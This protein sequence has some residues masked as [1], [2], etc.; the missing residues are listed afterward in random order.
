MS[1]PTLAA[2]VTLETASVDTGI[3]R[4]RKGLNQ[5]K[6]DTE[7]NMSASQR[8]FGFFGR[9]VDGVRDSI[10][11][12]NGAIAGAIG[13]A[14][15]MAIG[16]SVLNTADQV[17]KM[18]DRLGLT[19][20][21]L[22]KYQ[23]A[24]KLAGVE[25]EQFE[26]AFGF[27][28]R[29]MAEGKL[30]YTDIN[31]ALL[32]LAD[33]TQKA[34]DGIERARI[35]T[36]AFGARGG[37]RMIPFL[38]QGKEGIAALGAEAE[39]LGIVLGDDTIRKAEQFKDQLEILGDVIQKNFSQA[40]LEGFIGSSKD[41]RDIYTDPNF[42]QSI[43]DLGSAFGAIADGMLAAVS[44][45]KEFYSIGKKI[46]V[47]M[48]YDAA[49]KATRAVMGE[50][51]NPN[52]SFTKPQTV[53][54]ATFGSVEA[55]SEKE[56]AK[57]LS[58]RAYEEAAANKKLQATKQELTAAAKAQKEQEDALKKVY[59][60]VQTPLEK[61]HERLQELESMR[62]SLDPE[63][64]SRAVKKAGEEFDVA[65]QKADKLKDIGND[66]GLTF[67]SAFEDAIVSGKKLGDTMRSLGQ[68]ILRII[69][70]KAIT[71]PLTS[72]IG[73]LFSSAG[74]SSM[75]SSLFSGLGFASGGQPP[76]GKFSVVGERGP[77]LFMPSV[78]G[79]IIPNDQLGGS[80]NTYVIDARGTDESVVRRLE[81]SLFALAGP[82]VV[83]RRIADAQTRGAI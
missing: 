53:D 62:S 55:F 39:R 3:T 2:N 81:Q 45:L 6:Q 61:Y 71:E 76:V 13:G 5:L 46:L 40:A 33:K 7:R 48:P 65:S 8:A 38:M 80:S 77:E 25:T 79:T 57:L 12:M 24:A 29:Q 37:A 30:P 26:M 19:T 20:E 64:Y 28:N 54:Q 68:D 72:S 9:S 23:Y 14:G 63:I 17:A 51:Q 43:K 22:Q 18:S 1:N 56:K 58:D 67:S 66:L 10:L 78:R 82:G 60:D 32:A 35:A 34:K 15:F 16:R 47:D 59:E 73:S 27:L 75:F 31:Q 44:T 36:E 83:E 42:I 41:V 21:Q 69:T 49:Y 4:V 52:A 74:G 11:S 70:R 50:P